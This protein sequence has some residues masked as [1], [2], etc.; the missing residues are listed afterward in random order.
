[1]LVRDKIN[2]SLEGLLLMPPI[3]DQIAQNKEIVRMLNRAIEAGDGAR[4]SNLIS[5]DLVH[6]RRGLEATLPVLL[7]KIE[8]PKDAAAGFSA[9]AGAIGAVFDEWHAIEEQ[10]IAEGDYVVSRQTMRGRRRGDTDSFEFPM[11]VIFRIQANVITE[12]WA[13]GDELGFW[14]QL[15]M[16]LPD[17]STIVP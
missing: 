5:A 17:P 11:V 10:L 7:G 9:A 2:I 4:I 1:M 12:I 16:P 3:D 6:H 14:R 13:L 8:R 15:G